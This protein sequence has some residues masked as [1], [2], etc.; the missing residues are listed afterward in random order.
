M[1][2]NVP[3]LF[4]I[5]PEGEIGLSSVGWAKA[6]FL[7]ISRK[8]AEFGKTQPVPVFQAGEEV[9]DFRAG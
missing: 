1:L 4:W 9:R 3:T 6:D 2:T 8:M 5:A 7:E